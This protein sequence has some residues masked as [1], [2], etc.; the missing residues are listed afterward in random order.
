MSDDPIL[1]AKVGGPP[2]NWQQLL[3]KW[4]GVE[5]DSMLEVNVKEGWGIRYKRDQFNRFVIEND[6][7]QSEKIFG[8]FEI[9]IRNNGH[10]GI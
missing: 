1:Y 3:I 4:N 10:K 8:I 9:R 6:V 2:D 5:Q 7:A